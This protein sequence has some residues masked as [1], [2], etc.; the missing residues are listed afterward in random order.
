M[1]LWRPSTD[2]L[3]NK[4]RALKTLPGCE[5]QKKGEISALALFH[6]AAE[7]VPAYKKF[8]TEHNINHRK[9]TT[10]EEFARVPVV[11]KENYLRK[12]P[13]NE[14]VWDGTIG[15]ASM[16][17]RSSGSSGKPFY[18]LSNEQQRD[19]VG[20][21]YDLVF[22][23]MFNMRKRKTLVIVAYGMGS[24][25]AGTTTLLSTIGYMN[26]YNCTIMTP[27]YN[28]KEVIEICRDIGKEYEQ[29]VICAYPPL[30]K[31]I[32]DLGVQEG[33]SW[34]KLK[35]KFIFGAEAFSEDFRE[36]ILGKTGSTDHLMDT[37][38]TIGSADAMVI[39]HETPLSIALRRHISSKPDL[40]DSI[41]GNGRMPTLAQYYPWQK[42]LETFGDE[43]IITSNGAI[44]LIRYNIED[45][46]KLFSYTELTSLV[47]KK[48]YD[49]LSFVLPSTLR[50]EYN[51]KLPFVMLYGKST[52]AIKFYGAFIYPENI[53]AA[54][55]RSEN[56][57]LFTGKFRMEKYIDD[58]RDQRMR[59][60]VE[61]AP[62]TD[63]KSINM[64]YLQKNVSKVIADLNSEYKCVFQ[65]IGKKSV[66]M[67]KFVS[68]GEFD[69]NNTRNKHKYA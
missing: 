43:L 16:I 28:K 50:G 46:A 18:W 36:Y 66:P 19:H 64:K 38:N 5:W 35:P 69:L 24:W 53:K 62:G 59:I 63:P 27:G 1:K 26:K 42:Y 7:R 31:E 15:T 8:L 37:M 67:I 13:L 54:L 10:T 56:A 41:L 55:E 17:S 11:S 58:Y 61:L 20:E 34:R 4:I 14:L 2:S 25:V 29:V 12:Y 22:S 9:I 48:G 51:W 47:Q 33:I 23:S 57:H 49:D 60:F 44:P 40:H 39:G 65:D 21:F 45:N 52:N 30:V 6:E 32:I 3:E 68:Y